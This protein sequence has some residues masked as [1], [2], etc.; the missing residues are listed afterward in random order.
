MIANFRER[1]NMSADF[2]LKIVGW[3]QK[4]LQVRRETGDHNAIPAEEQL[5]YHIILCVDEINKSVNPG[6]L[7]HKLGSI[8]DN[9]PNINIV[10]S[11]LDQYFIKEKIEI[12]NNKTKGSNRTVVWFSLPLISLK[13]ALS[14]FAAHNPETN[15]DLLRCI[16]LANGHARTLQFIDLTLNDLQ[17]NSASA[18]FSAVSREMYKWLDSR[19]FTWEIICEALKGKPIQPKKKFFVAGEEQEA[20][21]LVASGYFINSRSVQKDKKDLTVSNDDDLFIPKMSLFHIQAYFLNKI[22]D[23]NTIFKPLSDLIGLPPSIQDPRVRGFWFEMFFSHWE[24][25]IRLV[26]HTKE[27]CGDTPFDFAQIIERNKTISLVKDIYGLTVL[28]DKS[29][30]N[31]EDY[32]SQ[33]GAFVFG[34]DVQINLCLTHE[35]TSKHYSKINKLPKLSEASFNTVFYLGGDNEGFD[36]LILERTPEGKP[37]AI[38]IE[39]KYSSPGTTNS[40]FVSRELLNKITS[41]VSFFEKTLIRLCFFFLIIALFLTTISAYSIE[42]RNSLKEDPSLDQII[43]EPFSRLDQIFFVALTFQKPSS[44]FLKKLREDFHTIRDQ[45][46]GETV[47]LH[48]QYPDSFFRKD[49]SLPNIVVLEKGRILELL[50]P[51]LSYVPEFLQ[52]DLVSLKRR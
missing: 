48:H 7:I 46:A 2:A 37:I 12:S 8:L 1:T 25:L 5:D 33:Q 45:E 31:L 24:R 32:R 28:N 4:L 9:N 40:K 47:K 19:D 20:R 50:S 44:T 13:G 27:D 11:T 6:A 35:G 22:R 52:D 14:M 15:S 39:F 38:F 10:T 34:K 43:S 3:H 30:L 42:F 26:L 41:S 49:R 21:D 17:G 23:S 18:L 16:C 51:T 29:P 36:T